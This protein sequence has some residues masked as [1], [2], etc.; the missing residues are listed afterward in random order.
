MNVEKDSSRLS[1]VYDIGRDDFHCNR[2]ADYL[3]EFDCLI[4]TCGY[5]KVRDRKPV[6]SADAF[7]LWFEQSSTILCTCFCNDRVCRH[8][9]SYLCISRNL[10]SMDVKPVTKYSL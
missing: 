6:G 1:L 4:H 10:V 9:C 3:C 2:K 5:L 8:G 7:C